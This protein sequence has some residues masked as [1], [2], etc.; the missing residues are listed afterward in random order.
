MIKMDPTYDA[1]KPSA[2]EIVK[3]EDRYATGVEKIDNQHKELIT[4][5]NDLYKACLVGDAATSVV[6]KD[7]LHRMVEY[8]RF[9]FGDELVTLKKINYP[10][11]NE[12]KRQHDELVKK[13]IDAVK[14]FEEGKRFV[15][16]NF[17]RDLKEW[18]FTHIGH[19]DKKYAMYIAELKKRGLIT[20]QQLLS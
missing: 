20:D 1:T 18:V 4:L 13:V 15:A 10:E 11:F 3:W 2:T 12:H 9:H 8:I 17:V 6:F 16:N 7:T 14:D 5:T 19:V